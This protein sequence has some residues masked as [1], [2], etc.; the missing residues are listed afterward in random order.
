M[1]TIRE[2]ASDACRNCN[3]N[4]SYEIMTSKGLITIT[5]KNC[6]PKT[7]R[8]VERVAGRRK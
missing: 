1:S 2:D 7:V 5:C 8:A 3:G 6:S 4:R